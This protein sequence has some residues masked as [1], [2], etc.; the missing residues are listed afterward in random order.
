MFGGAARM[1]LLLLALPASSGCSSIRG[2]GRFTAP[3]VAAQAEVSG[4]PA[5]GASA[6]AAAAC[7]CCCCCLRDRPLLDW[8]LMLPP[9]A[10]VAP[11][12]HDAGRSAASCAQAAKSVISRPAAARRG[13]RAAVR[14]RRGSFTQPIMPRNGQRHQRSDGARPLPPDAAATLLFCCQRVAQQ[15]HRRR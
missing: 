7:C 10:L 6:S 9:S 12:K 5:A 3:R 1:V 8:L 13:E 2:M 11:T 4:T 15:A 14:P